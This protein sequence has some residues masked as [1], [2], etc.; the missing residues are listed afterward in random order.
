MRLPEFLRSSH[1][2]LLFSE[3]PAFLT[4]G[5]MYLREA[6]FRVLKSSNGF[7]TIDWSASGQVN[8][9]VLDLDHNRE[10]VTL[11]AEEIKRLRPQLP[12]VVLTGGPEQH[13]ISGLAAAVVPK[14][15]SKRYWTRSTRC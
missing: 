12:T 3:D 11:M 8:T 7:E 6:G 5:S 1:T 15:K 2:F 14:K 13:A 9:V 4:L 10:E